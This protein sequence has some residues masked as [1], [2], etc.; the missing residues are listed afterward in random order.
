MSLLD[1]KHHLTWRQRI[2]VKLLLVIARIVGGDEIDAVT[3]S[4][5]ESTGRDINLGEWTPDSVSKPS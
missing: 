5:I 1:R 4:E 3:R 2:V